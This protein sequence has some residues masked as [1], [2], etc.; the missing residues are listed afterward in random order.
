MMIDD[1]GR[2]NQIGWLTYSKRAKQ[3]VARALQDTA[4]ALREVT[5]LVAFTGETD[6]SERLDHK[7]LGDLRKRIEN[8][9]FPQEEH[10]F[11]LVALQDFRSVHAWINAL[12]EARRLYSSVSADATDTLRDWVK[13]AIQA[14]SWAKK[15][16]DDLKNC[17]DV[18]FSFCSANSDDAR[19]LCGKFRKHKV[20]YFSY[21][22][23]KQAGKLVDQHIIEALLRSEEVWLLLT[24]DSLQSGWVTTEWGLAWG[25]GKP[26]V[27]VLRN[28]TDKDLPGRLKDRQ[29]VHFDDCGRAIKQLADR[30][31]R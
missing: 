22:R 4:S 3:D 25:A 10:G 1:E 28:C 14:E 6:K 7:R 18:F 21:E 31:G 13:L 12:D 19:L 29:Y 9:Q 16:E 24:P 11:L 5:D 23:T 17:P 2:M 15:M 26:I 20:E 27:P 8:G 30:L